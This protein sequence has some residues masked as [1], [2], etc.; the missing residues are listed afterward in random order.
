M[1]N[2]GNI[3]AYFAKNIAIV[4]GIVLVWRG[5]W[6]LLDM[7]DLFFFQGN[8]FYT[9]IVGIIVGLAILYFP[10]KDLK[11]LEKL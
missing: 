10:D 7:A 4:L 1:F 8:H 5:I 9:A 3:V 6:E 2:K 11:E